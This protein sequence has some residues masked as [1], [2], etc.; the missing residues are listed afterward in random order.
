[1]DPV[2]LLSGAMPERAGPIRR[3]YWRD[4]EFRGVCDDYRDARQALVKLEAELPASAAD[5]AHYR[6]LVAEL[7][8]EAMA[9]LGDE[10]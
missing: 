2:E 9:L 7:L 1:V 4:T 10:G 3:R 8:A 6:E 5:V